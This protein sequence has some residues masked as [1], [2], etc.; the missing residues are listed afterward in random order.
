MNAR[1]LD[2]YAIWIVLN[3]Y[4]V[5]HKSCTYLLYSMN[6]KIMFNSMLDSA[7]YQRTANLTLLCSGS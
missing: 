5:A 7:G 3:V 2:E 1:Y 4:V 6:M